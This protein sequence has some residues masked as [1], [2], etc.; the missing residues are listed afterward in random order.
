MKCLRNGELESQVM[1]LDETL[2]ILETMD[3][4][5][6]QWGLKYPNEA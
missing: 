6:T 5:R 4:L 3:T 2:T 1:P